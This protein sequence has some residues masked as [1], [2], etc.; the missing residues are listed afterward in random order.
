M[1]AIG[2]D[3]RIF[4]PAEVYLLTEPWEPLELLELHELLERVQSGGRR[5]GPRRETDAHRLADGEAG[6]LEVHVAC[7][8]LTHAVLGL[9]R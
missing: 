6:S 3:T 5:F 1:R 9:L 7:E 8:H 2:A 4:L